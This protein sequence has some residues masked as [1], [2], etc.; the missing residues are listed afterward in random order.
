EALNAM[1]N[2]KDRLLRDRKD[3]AVGSQ[4]KAIE[5]MQEG[6]QAMA[7]KL[8]EGKAGRGRG[9]GQ[10]RT[11]P[12]GRPMPQSGMTTGEDVAVPDRI[13]MQRARQ[14]LEELR[15]RAREL[16]RPEIELDYLDRLLRRF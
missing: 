11:D 9:Q 5:R 8:M 3:L 7:D 14:I 1:K 15:E 13:D 4:G 6:A 10:A 12:F 2:A 16:G